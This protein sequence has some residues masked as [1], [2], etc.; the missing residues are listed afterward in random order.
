M[1]DELLDKFY[2]KNEIVQKIIKNLLEDVFIIEPSAGNGAFIKELKNEYIA[3]DILPEYENIINADFLEI[4]INGYIPRN[5][6]I[7][8][9]GNPPFGKQANLAVKFF[10]KCAEFSD[11]IWF[12]VPRTF[13]KKSIHRRLNKYFYLIEEYN[14]PENSFLF[15]NKEYNV[16]CCFQKWIKCNEKRNVEIKTTTKY[17]DFVKKSNNPDIAVRRVGINAG[18]YFLD[19]D[20][21]ES[22][23][24]FLKFKNKNHIEYFKTLYNDLY[25][26][27]NN[28][29]GCRSISKDE[30][31]NWFEQKIK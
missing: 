22:S 5:K 30:L 4:N 14:L 28:T 27:G 1:N 17:F 18:K 7:I 13:Q 23:F 12:I 6:K 25:N 10:N 15:K 26:I 21:S 19:I 31:I 20:K 3:F 11:E 8:S 2:T 29:A 16:T 9:L 24:Y